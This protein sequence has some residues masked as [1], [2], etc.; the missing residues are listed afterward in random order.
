M[1]FVDFVTIN[2]K[3]G[4]GG[5]GCVSL[6]REKYIPKGGPDGG[7]GGR[8]GDVIIKAASDLNTLLDFK[9]HPFNKAEQ[10]SMG[11]GNNRHGRNGHDLA[12]R[13]PVGT[14]IRDA[15]TGEVLADLVADGQEVVAAKGGRGGLGNAHFATPTRQTPRFAQPGTPGEAKRLQLELKLLADV[16]LVGLPN[17]G[18]STLISVA[19]KS[20]PKIAD[21]PFTTLVPNLGVVKFE[22]MKSF[23]VAD[24]PG[25]I[26]G[27]HSGSGLGFQFLRHIERTSVL[28]HLVDVSDT[29]QQEDPVNN[30]ETIMQ[31]LALFDARLAQKP[32]LVVGTKLDISG[33][34]LNLN[35]LARY[36][37]AK[38]LPFFAISA[39]TGQGVKELIAALLKEV[40]KGR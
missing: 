37:E 30:F 10:G 7:D 33:D 29:D 13:V 4:D 31:E 8:G 1:H 18:K 9:Y 16:G 36:C 28:A 6:H 5:R 2:V 26:E 34:K 15:D 11:G 12:L 32:L 22:D 35:R 23:C 21:Y 20:R 38:R 27:A 39:V 40:E 24:I 3:A 25:L 17:A 14:I 19:S